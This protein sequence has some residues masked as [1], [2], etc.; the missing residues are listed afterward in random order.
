MS[1]SSP[2]VTFLAKLVTTSLAVLIVAYL[3][4]GV[5]VDSALSAIGLSLVLAILN[6]FIKPLLVLLTLPITIVTLGLFLIVVNALII[7]LAD[8]IVPGFSVDGFWWAVLFSLILS[9]VVSVLE[10]IQIA[11]SGKD[12]N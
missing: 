12:E 9:V 6:I 10:S 8:E 2:A 11:A 4:P 1:N 7:L 3:L 5:T